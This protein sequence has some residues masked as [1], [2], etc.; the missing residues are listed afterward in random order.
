M[1]CV[2]HS[3]YTG[4]TKGEE[5]NKVFTI[6]WAYQMRFN[7]LPYGVT[8]CRFSL[9]TKKM[10]SKNKDNTEYDYIPCYVKGN[11]AVNMQKNLSD[12]ARISMWSK[13]VLDD[14]GRLTLSVEEIDFL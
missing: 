3:T 10:I 9:K 13:M 5:M 14:I 12:G 2:G 6:G 4:N 11:K 7:E 8:E 1:I